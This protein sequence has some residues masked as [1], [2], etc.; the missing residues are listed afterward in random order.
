L[1]VPANLSDVAS[2]IAVAM[3]VVKRK[4]DDAAMIGGPR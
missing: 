1:I 3:N 4:D 2:M